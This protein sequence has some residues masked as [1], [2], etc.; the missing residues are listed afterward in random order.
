MLASGL[1]R[2]TGQ[3]RLADWVWNFGWSV[4]KLQALAKANTESLNKSEGGSGPR[5][6]D[7]YPL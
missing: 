4:G 2:P 3:R 5:S 7:R 6:A 1:R